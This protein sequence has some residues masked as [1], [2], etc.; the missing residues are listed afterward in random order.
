MIGI[1]WSQIRS[2]GSILLASSLAIRDGR[3]YAI[4]Y[5]AAISGDN[6]CT[7]LKKAIIISASVSKNPVDNPTLSNLYF[8]TFSLEPKS[9]SMKSL[10]SSVYLLKSSFIP[11]SNSLICGLFGFLKMKLY[12]VFVLVKYAVI[13]FTGHSP[14]VMTSGFNALIISDSISKNKISILHTGF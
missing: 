8:D 14:I 5:A 4:L 10:T 1:S 11:S 6:S 9:Y 2:L 3:S 13:A 7:R 12:K